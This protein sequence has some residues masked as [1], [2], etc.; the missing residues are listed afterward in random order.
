MRHIRSH[1]ALAAM[2]GLAVLVAA[3]C[4]SAE[5][6]GDDPTTGATGGDEAP[7]EITISVDNFPST[8]EPENRAAFEAVVASFELRYPHITIDAQEV[9][10][11]P[12]TF[13]ALLAGGTMT[14]V[15]GVPFT[16]MAVLMEREQVADI[17]EQFQASE[18]FA[19]MNPGLVDIVTDDDGNVRGVP[20]NAYTMGLLYNRDLFTQAGLDPDDPPQT[21]DDVREAASAITENTDAYGFQ[22]MTLDNTGGWALATTS[23]GFGSTLQSEDGTTATVDN[24]ATREAL[25]FYRTL[26][27]DD[28][29]MGD[30]FL[31]GYGDANAAFASGQVGM[32]VQGADNYNDMVVNLGMDPQHFGVAPLPQTDNGLGTLGGGYIQV[33]NPSASPEEIEAALLW[34]EHQHL[35]QYTDQDTAVERAQDQ[36]EAGQSVGTIALRVVS[37]ELYDQYLE[38]IG[39]YI[40]VPRENFSLYLDTVDTLP[41][42]PEPPRAAQETYAALDPIVQAVL[43]DQS[44]DI[45]ALLAEAQT[46]VQ[47]IVDAANA[48]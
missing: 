32:F 10:W 26:R 39:E 43:T 8:E 38:W 41:L 22:T 40:N 14:T 24:D 3:G 5:E 19:D 2:A 11:D 35:L 15:F 33:L 27:W 16:E 48:G 21:W 34:V 1:S 23:Y 28:N 6:P 25:E 36:V 9:N 46:N 31:V 30:N 37:E 29:A 42:V 47:A 18:V 7:Q 20:V 4:S 17:T 45:D 44:A 13:Q 12:Q